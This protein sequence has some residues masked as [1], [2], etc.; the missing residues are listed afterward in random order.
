MADDIS[1]EKI[2]EL[3]VTVIKMIHSETHRKKKADK[4][5]NKALVKC[6]TILSDKIYE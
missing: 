3:E 5:M 1:K 4:K 6:E 2:S